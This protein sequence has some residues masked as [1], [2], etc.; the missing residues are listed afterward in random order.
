VRRGAAWP[1]K[2]PSSCL[3]WRWSSPVRRSV[4]P[5]VVVAAELSWLVDRPDAAAQPSVQRPSS[6]QAPSPCSTCQNASHGVGRRSASSMGVHP[7]GS[8]VRGPAVRPVQ[9]PVRPVSS[10][11]GS[12]SGIRCPAV[13]CPPV[14]CPAVWGRPRP[15]GRVR[16]VPI[17]RWHWGQA[18]AARQP[19]PR[20]R[21]Q[22][23][24]GCRVVER[25]GS[26]AEQAR[27]RATPP[28]SPMVGGAV[29]AG[30]GPGRAWAAAV[31]DA[32]LPGRPGGRAERPSPAAARRAREAAPATRLPFPGWVGDHGAWLSRRLPPTW[33]GPEGPMGL[34][35]G[36]GVRPQRGPGSQRALP[37]CCRQR[38]DLRRWLVGLPGLE[39][40]T[41]S[42]SGFCSRACFRRIAPATC[43]N[44]LPLETAGDRCEPLGSDGVWTK[45]GPDA[46]I[47]SHQPS[48][49]T[50]GR[51]PW[52][53]HADPSDE[54]TG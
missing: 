33:T 14:R 43:A 2:R 35:A 36:M 9:C 19:A 13:W 47:R 51:A 41:S 26:T 54:Q 31:L 10:H 16:L 7:S 11:L 6:G 3:S 40:G 42:L 39:P 23:P 46:R 17:R 27:T 38:S 29:G 20:E 44:D 30:P 21:V 24:V 4:I 32:G 18:D 15:S 8:V 50:A 37:A 28:R 52:I 34:P 12:S 48:R 25:L 49:A 53:P 45:R 1:A 22:V 5:L